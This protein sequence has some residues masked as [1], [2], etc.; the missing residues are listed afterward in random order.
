MLDLSDG[1][2]DNIDR[3]FGN[4]PVDAHL[5]EDL[6][7]NKIAFVIALNFP[8]FTLGEKEALGPGWNREQWAMARL[9]NMFVSRVPS[10]LNQLLAEA[11]GNS[12]MYIAGYNIYMGHLLTED[13]RRL[14]P[15][16]MILLSHWTFVMNLKRIMPKGYGKKAGDDIQGMERIIRQEIP[17]RSSTVRIMMGTFFK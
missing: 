1:E 3:M 13:K 4:Y 10:G 12:E 15:E 16:D 14:F 7:S 17:L 9:G 6:F 11:K 5:R 2:I 8:Y